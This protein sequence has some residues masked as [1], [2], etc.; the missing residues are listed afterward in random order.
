MQSDK[1]TIC[2]IVPVRAG[3]KRVPNKNMR[4][5]AGTTLLELKIR[6][7]RLVEAIEEIYVSSDSE[8]MLD[9]AT[10]LQCKA[11]KRPASLASDMI[12]MSDVYAHLA[13]SVRE[14]LIVFTHV[15]NPLCSSRIY[16][17]AID[18]YLKRAAGYDSLT[19]VSDVKEFLYMGGKAINFDPRNKP[20][21]QDLPDIVKLNHA[22]SIADR[23]LMVRERN[24]F[25]PNP[26]LMKLTEIDAFDIDT[27]IDFALAEFLFKRIS[28]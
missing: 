7:L 5:F 22:V 12:P 25:G 11:L 19:T 8:E 13:Q 18:T 28:L 6:Q 15:T 3:S 27:E 4:P 20:R 21:S 9:L 10:A 2:A 26:I 17:E 16:A 24:I 23:E 14:K 1:P